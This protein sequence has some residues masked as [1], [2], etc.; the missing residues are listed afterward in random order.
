M[1]NT[2]Q[3]IQGNKFEALKW[4][5]E[6]QTELLY[7]LT[8]ID[9]QLFSG[10]ITMQVAIGGWLV[11]NSH[12]LSGQILRRIDVMVLVDLVLA[13]VVG[14]LLHRNYKR[15][16]QV[17]KI[18]RQCNKDMGFDEL[19]RIPPWIN[20]YLLGIAATAIGIALVVFGL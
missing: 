14:A 10:F 18:V 4:R 1:A 11:T 2:P 20:L 19:D 12:K 3:V 9:L 7:R 6:N 8:K 5:F 17:G 15:R 16:E 13:I